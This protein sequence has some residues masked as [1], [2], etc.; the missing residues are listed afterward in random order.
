MADQQN[1]VNTK[2]KVDPGN[3]I[4][5]LGQV[6]RSVGNL[7]RTLGTVTHHLQSMTGFALVGF[8]QAVTQ[9]DNLYDAVGRVK[10]IT[11]S[12][13]TSIDAAMDVMG[14]FGL[15]VGEAEGVLTKMARKSMA[16]AGGI[17][18]TGKQAAEAA[19]K[20]KQMGVDIKAGPEL[21]LEQMSRAAMAGKLQMDGLVQTFGVP[22]TKAGAMMEMLRKG[23]AEVKRLMA[24]QKAG[25]AS[26]T[27]ESLASYKRMKM[28]R[29]EA[30]DAFQDII[31]VFYRTLFPVV[32]KALGVIQAK[33]EQWAPVA[34]KVGKI[35]VDNMETVIWLA[36]K[37]VKLLLISKALNA[38]TG[39]GIRDNAKKVLEYSKANLLVGGAKAA[40]PAAAVEAA[41]A[42]VPRGGRRGKA[43]KMIGLPDAPAGR[44]GGLAGMLGGFL[45]S[46][47]KGIGGV[48][49]SL[50][51]S[52]MAVLRPIGALLGMTI[53]LGA[54][55][56]IAAKMIIIGA[57]VG[58][59]AKAFQLV[60]TNANGIKDRLV[61]L[62]DKIVVQFRG[63]S[64]ALTPIIDALGTGLT[65][66]ARGV[67]AVVEGIMAVVAGI[68]ILVRA[69]GTYLAMMTSPSNWSRPVAA[70]KDAIREAQAGTAEAMK[71]REMERAKARAD[72][73]GAKNTAVDKGGVYQD[74]RGSKFDITQ[75]FAE[76]YDAD[77]VA[78]VF[79]SDISKLGERR[80]QS[81]LAPLYSV[82]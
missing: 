64:G 14:K 4:G 46:A 45:G 77:R 70:F 23:P 31:Q 60:A 40:A 39:A 74:F 30:A 63:V 42:F 54:L 21:Q 17:S 7:G 47:G 44:G 79:G 52:V 6:Y 50:G 57:V 2:L 20:F 49:K 24:D 34:E 10:A 68:L 55:A 28:A 9:V 18:A 26:I 80:L 33:L 61:S 66:A 25:I 35:L 19:A 36:E 65:W 37:Y 11:G 22:L 51:G 82:R 32:A 15:E 1:N 38:V 13:A 8:A 67:L 3:T 48:F 73:M 27:D 59:I 29:S 72:A 75:T 62:L 76:G 5:A 16:A 81:G 53:K 43:L 69:I 58:V 78:V 12:S 41:S 56:V 71:L